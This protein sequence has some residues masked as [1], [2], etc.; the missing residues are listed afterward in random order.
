[1]LGNETNMPCCN[2][3]RINYLHTQHNYNH[4]TLS[5]KSQLDS[6]EN[7]QKENYTLHNNI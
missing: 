5:I 6:N 2:V 3:L 7:V 1:M 4:V